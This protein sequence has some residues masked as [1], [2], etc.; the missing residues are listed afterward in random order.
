MKLKKAYFI[1]EIDG[2]EFV[3]QDGCS[4][5]GPLA[6]KRDLRRLALAVVGTNLLGGKRK[7][8]IATEIEQRALDLAT[9]RLAK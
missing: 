2:E 9:G 7:N 1:W 8:R 5:C 6:T 4:M 3:L